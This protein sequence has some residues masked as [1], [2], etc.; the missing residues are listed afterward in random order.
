MTYFTLK[1]EAR[2][3]S[4]EGW[5]DNKAEQHAIKLLKMIWM[6]AMGKAKETRFHGSD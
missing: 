2:L 1:L 4:K 6:I 3:E 5:M